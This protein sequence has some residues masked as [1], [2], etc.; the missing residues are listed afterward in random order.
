M[1]TITFYSNEHVSRLLHIETEGCVVNIRVD[2][3]D[4]EARRVTSVEILPNTSDGYWLD[5]TANN[6]IVKATKNREG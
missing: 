4:S 5:G 6:R 2:L 3:R 1:K